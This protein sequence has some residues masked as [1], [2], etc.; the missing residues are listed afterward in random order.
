MLLLLLLLLF[1]YI[2]RTQSIQKRGQKQRE[3]ELMSTCLMFTVRWLTVDCCCV[4]YIAKHGKLSEKNA[5]LKFT[6]I[7]DAVD[8]CHRCRVVH[9]D[10]KVC[11]HSNDN[12]TNNNNDNNNNKSARNNLG[13]GP[14]RGAVAHVRRKVPIGYNCPPKTRPQKYPFPWTDP[15]TPLRCY[16]PHPW[17]RPTYDA[18][19]RIRSA[20]FQQCTGQTDARTHRQIVYGKIWRL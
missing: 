10:L 7:I 20:F 13:R 14:R 17:T 8:Y 11:F 3:S 5:R 19:I 6:Q 12:N 4:D 2:C 9:R 18:G 1:R 16:L 15:E